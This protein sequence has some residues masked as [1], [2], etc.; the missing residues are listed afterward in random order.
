MKH[1]SHSIAFKKIDNNVTSPKY[2]KTFIEKNVGIKSV[3][4]VVKLDTVY[5]AMQ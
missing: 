3:S 2:N 5:G 1:Y 4:V